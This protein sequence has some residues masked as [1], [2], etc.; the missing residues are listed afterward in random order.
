MATKLVY[1]TLYLQ[2]SL[3]V[4]FILISA[5]DAHIDGHSSAPL[6]LD[7]TCDEQSYFET[8]FQIIVILKDLTLAIFAFQTTICYSPLPPSLPSPRLLHQIP[9]QLSERQYQAPLL[10]HLLSRQISGNVCIQ[11]FI[12]DIKEDC[13]DKSGTRYFV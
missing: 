10:P 8:L 12:S 1:F 5:Q 7:A 11:N 6:D 13:F 2:K 4:L 9:A 3:T